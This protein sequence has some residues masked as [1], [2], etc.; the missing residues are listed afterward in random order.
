MYK[1]DILYGE[2]KKKKKKGKKKEIKKSRAICMLRLCGGFGGNVWGG[3]RA[4][5]PFAH[6]HAHT[7][8]EIHPRTRV[9]RER[10]RDTHASAYT[11]ACFV[12]T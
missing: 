6:I 7:H 9:D 2:A 5:A 3:F 4:R 8:T 11:I 1:V 10:E 12:P